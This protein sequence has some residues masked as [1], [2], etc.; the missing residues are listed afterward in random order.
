VTCGDGVVAAAAGQHGSG[1]QR[2]WRDGLRHGG[3]LLAAAALTCSAWGAAC[4]E[5]RRFEEG[6]MVGGFELYRVIQGGVP[7]A[8]HLR[9]S[10]HVWWPRHMLD[11][12]R[13]LCLGRSRQALL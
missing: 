11:V 12:R 8:V 13:A 3:W 5:S 2:A 9:P 4:R 10:W 7:A 1:W 6:T